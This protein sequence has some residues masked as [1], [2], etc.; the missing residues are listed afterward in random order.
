MEIGEDRPALTDNSSM[1]EFDILS[2]LVDIC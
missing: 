2:E 1:K